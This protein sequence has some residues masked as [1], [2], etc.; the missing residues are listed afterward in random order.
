MAPRPFSWCACG[1]WTYNFRLL[2]NGGF[3]GKCGEQV[4]LFKPDAAAA[5]GN[6]KGKKGIHS[7]KGGKGEDKSAWHFGSG[8]GTH[9]W[10]KEP[11]IS[12][13]LSI[14]SNVPALAEHADV[15]RQADNSFM[16]SKAK[17]VSPNQ[18]VY[19]C[20]QTLEKKEM[21]LQKAS[22]D[23]IKLETA[24]QEAKLWLHQ[25]AEEALSAK[26][27]HTLAV[28]ALADST[29]AAKTQDGYTADGKKIYLAMDE[30]DF[31]TSDEFDDAQ[32]A[33]LKAIQKQVEEHCKKVEDL[34]KTMQEALKSVKEIR[35]APAKRQRGQD[36]PVPGPGA[37]EA[38]GPDEDQAPAAEDGPTIAVSESDIAAKIAS[39]REATLASM[40]DFPPLGT[41]NGDTLQP[42]LPPH[43][44]SCIR[45]PVPENYDATY[46]FSNISEWGPQAEGFMKAQAE[47]YDVIGFAEMHLRGVKVLDFTEKISKDGWKAAVTAAA[48][49]GR[50]AEGTTGGEAI[51]SK[52][53]LATTTFE[54]WRKHEIERSAVDPFQGFCP[55]TWHTKAGNIVVISA[56]MQPKHGLKGPNEK[57]MI[58]LQEE[59]QDAYEELHNWP[60]MQD[61]HSNDSVTFDIPIEVWRSAAATVAGLGEDK[62]KHVRKESND[63]QDN[64]PSS[65]FLLTRDVEAQK[66]VAKAF[67]DWV[68]TVEKATLKHHNIPEYQLMRRKFAEQDYKRMAIKMQELLHIA[69]ENNFLDKYNDPEDKRTLE[70][71]TKAITDLDGQNIDSLQ[72]LLEIGLRFQ[73]RAVGTGL[74]NGRRAFASWVTRMWK[75]APGALH[76]HVKP[77]TTRRDEHFSH[78]GSTYATPCE[79]MDRRAD[80]WENIWSDPSSDHKSI[81]DGLKYVT[82]QAKREDVHPIELEHLD[83]LLAKQNPKKARGIDNLGPLEVQ[84]LPEPGRRQ[85]VEVLNLCENYL[86][87]PHQIFTVIGR[88]LTSALAIEY[89]DDDPAKRIRRQ[90]IAAWLTMWRQCPGIHDRIRQSWD[91]ILDRIRKAGQRKWRIVRGPVGATI[92]TLLEINWDPIAATQWD[93][94][95][96]KSWLIPAREDEDFKKLNADY[97]EI[98]NDINSSV[99]RVLWTRASKHEAGDD[100]HSGGDFSTIK[101]EN[102]RLARREQYSEIALNTVVTTGG[103]W[104]R[105]RMLAAGYEVP[106]TCPRCGEQDESLFHRIWTCAANCNHDD[107]TDSE[108]LTAQAFAN[109]EASP[110][111]WLRGVPAAADTIP[112]FDETPPITNSFGDR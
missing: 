29:G 9:P 15:F 79:I 11:D 85:M 89:G 40:G 82:E 86:M 107:Y 77:A 73:A 65:H 63:D 42:P 27:A 56:C 60:T 31:A 37:A 58:R 36:G 45:A 18:E 30:F 1:N 75:Q 106:P 13:M 10:S 44:L 104:T 71:W 92:A 96:G 21:A 111:L 83:H 28:K 84:R 19:R 55:T 48:P 70:E 35:A 46:F 81:L 74:A 38:E 103:Q 64:Y 16:A 93:T 52:R 54:G 110:S 72:A 20:S 23:V 22:A 5:K 61:T 78:E 98:F 105:T 33:Q 109:Y 68:Q 47:Q 69:T 24:L 6:G 12:Q 97:S 14:L 76:R 90:Q 2:H 59:L 101:Q 7:Y 57:M 26:R 95:A 66:K 32:K 50:A 41:G 91:K 100:L 43:G 87:W 112:V 80:F 3:C 88:C 8:K 4:T 17:P 62:G 39:A 99:D 102:R 67:G 34:Q 94:D 51:I 25:T 49:S 53:S 108:F